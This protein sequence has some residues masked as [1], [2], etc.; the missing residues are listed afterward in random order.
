M[1]SCCICGEESLLNLCEQ[2]DKIRVFV[3]IWGINTVL[4]WI[5]RY[6]IEAKLYRRKPLIRKNV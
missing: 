4:C 3:D 6:I 5:N 1:V 2:C